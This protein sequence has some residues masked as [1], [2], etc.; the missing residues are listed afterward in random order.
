MKFEKLMFVNESLGGA[1][2]PRAGLRD[3]PLALQ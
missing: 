1:G 3:H 2:L